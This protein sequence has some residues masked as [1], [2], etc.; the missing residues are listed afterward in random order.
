MTNGPVASRGSGEGPDT[1]SHQALIVFLKNP[2]PGAVKTRL[3]PALGAETAADLYRALAE[4]VLR[5]TV[6][7]GGEYETLAFF[8][9]PEARDAMRGWLPG[10]RLRAQSEGDL[11]E[12]MNAAFDRVFERG[13]RR[14]AIIGTD[15]PGVTSH[16]VK[17]ALA[18]LEGAP[19]VVG[20]AEDGG[21]YLLAL[22]EPHPELFVDMTWSAPTVLEETE[23]RA[24]EAGL[25][26]HR[27]P[28]LR[29]VDTLDDLR[30][31]WPGLRSR[32][33]DH[34]GLCRRIDEV[35]GLPLGPDR[36]D[37]WPR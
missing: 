12:R 14:V 35:L 6:P 7:P 15:V 30:A 9:P 31:E 28:T 24:R 36:R 3:V 4:E 13:A 20:P 33:A 1:M 19:V 27:R 16:V 21:Y 32:L 37:E 17:G 11:G 2:D 29:D 25:T 23:R 34:P 8:A 22:R 18:A 10:L 5:A 26:V